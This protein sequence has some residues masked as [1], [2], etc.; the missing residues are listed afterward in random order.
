MRLVTR[1]YAGTG[2]ERILERYGF[3]ASHISE[4][5]VRQM[6]PFFWDGWVGRSK[7]LSLRAATA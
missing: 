2:A 5:Y 6:P 7:P 1:V 3:V 4:E